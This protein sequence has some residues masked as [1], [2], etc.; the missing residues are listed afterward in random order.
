VA[1]SDEL[2]AAAD[3]SP[4]SLELPG[5]STDLFDSM[6]PDFS[7]GALELTLADIDLQNVRPEIHLPS[8]ASR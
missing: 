7:N 1:S 2:P 3:I 5:V 4:D 8:C 6:W